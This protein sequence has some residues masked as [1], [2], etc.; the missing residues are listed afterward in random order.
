MF[1]DI[2]FEYQLTKMKSLILLIC[3]LA[4]GGCANNRQQ[5]IQTLCK[6]VNSTGSACSSAVGFTGKCADC[7]RENE[8]NE[9]ELVKQTD[10]SSLESKENSLVW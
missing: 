2:N 5:A 4:L 7:M 10:I 8:N 9:L 1:F 3:L 6:G